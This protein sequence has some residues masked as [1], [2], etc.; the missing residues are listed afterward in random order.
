MSSDCLSETFEYEEALPFCL[1]LLSFL[2]SFFFQVADVQLIDS[3]YGFSLSELLYRSGSGAVFS[4]GRKAKQ[5]CEARFVS[6][7]PGTV[8]IG[9][10]PFGM[11]PEQGFVH[12]L[13]KLNVNLNVVRTRL[14]RVRIHAEYHHQQATSSQCACVGF[15]V[16]TGEVP[17]PTSFEIGR[18]YSSKT[19]LKPETSGLLSRITD[20]G[21]V[22][23]RSL[24]YSS[25]KIPLSIQRR[26][27]VRWPQ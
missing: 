6:L 2:E 21:L 13:L 3:G 18:W 10:N 23:W 8:A 11:L 19:G 9:L 22:C 4:R 16:A 20:R 1:S 14:R 26:L 5:F 17:C 27:K 25:R 24:S 7:A 12:L 15:S